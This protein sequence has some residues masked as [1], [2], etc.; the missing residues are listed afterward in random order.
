M[1]DKYRHIAPLLMRLHNIDVSKYDKS[2]LDKSLQKRIAENKLDSVEEYCMLIKR[3]EKELKCFIDSLN[4]CYSEFF[5]S[6]LTFAV[7]NR[8]IFPP[9]IFNNKNNKRREIRIWSAA[10]AG[11]QEAYSLA[12]LLEDLK[13]SSPDKFGYRIFATDQNELQI[14]TAKKGR[15]NSTALRNLNLKQAADWFIKHGEIY[16]VKPNLKEHIDFSVFDLFNDEFSSPPSSIFGSFDIIFCTNILFYYD[17]NSRGIILEKISN[18]L[19]EG[20]LIITGEA[21]RE[22]LIDLNYYEVYPQSSIFRRI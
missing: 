1:N 8:I 18:S 10:C 9:L 21:E 17:N 20:G 6:P 11:G 3:S 12:I 2:F 13:N 22:I 16:S 14:E 4:N 15:Y 5:R 7:L 19:A